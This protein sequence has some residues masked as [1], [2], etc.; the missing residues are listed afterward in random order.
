ME[1]NEINIKSDYIIFDFKNNKTDYIENKEYNSKEEKIKHSKKNNIIYDYSSKKEISKNEIA[2]NED[3]EFINSFSNN[4]S[5]K[6]SS[7]ISSNINQ[8]KE[9]KAKTLLKFIN[10]GNSHINNLMKLKANKNKIIFKNIK[11]NSNFKSTGQQTLSVKSNNYNKIIYSLKNNS[12]SSI[13]LRNDNI[14]SVKANT[15]RCK[16]L[17]LIKNKNNDKEKNINISKAQFK[18]LTKSCLQLNNLSKKNINKKLSDLK[19]SN[20]IKNKNISSSLVN[21]EQYTKRKNKKINIPNIVRRFNFNNKESNYLLNNSLINRS[22]N[23]TKGK[24][25]FS[26]ILFSILNNNRDKIENKFQFKL[27][28]PS[29]INISTLLEMNKKNV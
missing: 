1:N 3:N 9:I 20:I 8:R 12:M 16:D 6:S 10:R 4:I 26:Q 27:H 21:I 15:T 18:G 24:N 5:V 11:N 19:K 7:I 2:K 29:N 23:N 28:K 14:L 25:I 22:K 17:C 13:I